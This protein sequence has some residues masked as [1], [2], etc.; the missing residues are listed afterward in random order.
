MRPLVPRFADSGLKPIQSPAN[1]KDM[2]R[3]RCQM[4]RLS[5]Y[6]YS[7]FSRPTLNTKFD[8]DTLTVATDH[9]QPV[10]RV[11]VAIKP[12]E[13]SF[14]PLVVHREARQ[15]GRAIVF[16]HSPRDDDVRD[17]PDGAPRV[18]PD[19]VVRDDV[20]KG[21]RVGRVVRVE[22]L[23]VVADLVEEFFVKG[24]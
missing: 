10:A 4:L 16:P 13:E 19:A 23:L 12:R 9:E 14:H 3:E 15:R 8:I 22:A 24:L 1:T 21:A 18:A 5:V 11:G 2:Y 17:L 6:T 20:G 7:S